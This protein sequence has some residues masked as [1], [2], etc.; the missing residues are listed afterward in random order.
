M[1][2]GRLAHGL[3]LGRLHLQRTAEELCAAGAQG[4]RE[5]WLTLTL[6]T[7]QSHPSSRIASHDAQ[8]AINREYLR[9]LALPPGEVRPSRLSRDARCATTFAPARVA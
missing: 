5:E 7:T 6:P 4:P 2:L 3:G 8:R 9:A 1:A